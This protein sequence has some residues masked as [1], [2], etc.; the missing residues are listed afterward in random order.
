[1]LQE[2]RSN[3][4]LFMFFHTWAQ[5]QHEFVPARRAGLE[6]RWMRIRDM[7]LREDGRE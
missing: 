1:M 7:V 6:R 2:N 5:G 4:S 3:K